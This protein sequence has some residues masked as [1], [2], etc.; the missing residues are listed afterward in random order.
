M[1]ITSEMLEAAAKAAEEWPEDI[2]CTSA[3]VVSEYGCSIEHID[4]PESFL[5]P[6][7][8]AARIMVDDPTTIDIN[9]LINIFDE[10][11]KLVFQYAHRIDQGEQE[12]VAELFRIIAQDENYQWNVGGC[13]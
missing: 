12:E 2:P 10:L 6:A 1:K 3:W 5:W 11:D 9:F 4:D 7:A 13:R 8:A